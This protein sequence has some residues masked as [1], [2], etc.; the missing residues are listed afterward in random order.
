MRTFTLDGLDRMLE[1]NLLL[2]A[3]VRVYDTMLSGHIIRTND[4]SVNER[5]S[6]SL[7]WQTRLLQ[8]TDPT[9][10]LNSPKLIEFQHTRRPHSLSRPS[11]L[12]PVS[13]CN[14][15][16]YVKIRKCILTFY[17]SLWPCIATTYP[18][19]TACTDLNMEHKWHIHQHRDLSC[20][21]CTGRDSHCSPEPLNFSNVIYLSDWTGQ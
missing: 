21:L 18:V 16:S 7:T 20:R 5:N 11:L 3:H 15:E 14:L 6:L 12:P 13:F 2:L 4:L 10:P 19:F 17:Y 8:A 9:S 1:S